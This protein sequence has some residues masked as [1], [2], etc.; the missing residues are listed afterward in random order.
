MKDRSDKNNPKKSGVRGGIAALMES[1]LKF[2]EL[3]KKLRNASLRKKKKSK[4]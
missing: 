3:S 4:K 2:R 1:T